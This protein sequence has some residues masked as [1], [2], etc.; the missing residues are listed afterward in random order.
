MFSVRA[1]CSGSCDA[2]TDGCAVDDEWARAASSSGL[3]RMSARSCFLWRESESRSSVWF[4]R[5]QQPASRRSGTL[6]TICPRGSW[7]ASARRDPESAVHTLRHG[8]GP[9][10]T[11]GAL[12]RTH[13]NC[14]RLRAAAVTVT[15]TATAT[16]IAIAI[17]IA[18]AIAKAGAGV[19]A[20]CSQQ[21]YCGDSPP[22]CSAW[23]VVQERCWDGRTA[24]PGLAGRAGTG[25]TGTTT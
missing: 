14:R 1:A 2:A 9:G 24:S 12:L 22:D 8:S 25:A 17:A 20:G 7:G 5:A 19:K 13:R 15:V 21:E 10:V 18:T 23:A 11:P 6:Q 16:A 4:Q 3:A